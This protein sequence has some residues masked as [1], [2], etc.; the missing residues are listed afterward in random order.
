MAANYESTIEMNVSTYLIVGLQLVEE[1][2]CL[3][4]IPR[5]KGYI[6]VGIANLIGCT[7]TKVSEVLPR[8]P[9][10]LKELPHS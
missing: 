1:F 5:P 7:F 4:C 3:Q 10:R 2:V 8:F 9:R 6:V